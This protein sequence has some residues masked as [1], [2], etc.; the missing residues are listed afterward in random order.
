MNYCEIHLGDLEKAT[1]HLTGVE[2]GM[3]WRLMRWYYDAET[4][5]PLD[6]KAIQRKARAR[7]REE[8]EAVETVLEEFFVQQADGWHQKRCDEEIAKYQAK[9]EKARR[10]AEA[11]WG[12]RPADS[13]R[14]AN[15]FENYA[16]AS[17]EGN[18]PID[19]NA[20]TEQCERNAHQSPVTSHQ[21]PD[22]KQILPHTEIPLAEPTAAGRACLLMRRAGCI[23]TNPSHPALIAALDAGASPEELADTAREAVEAGKN[24]PFAWACITARSR[25]EQLTHGATHA[26][27]PDRGNRRRLSVVERVERN[28]AERERQRQSPDERPVIDAEAVRV[29][30]G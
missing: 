19:A 18:P 12:A 3:Y 27:A 23:Q 22:P 2:D 28:V 16:N 5:L 6:L 14:N 21:S 29:D 17:S 25:R 8:K 10:S 20:S 1:A 30:A 13:E 7:S 15:A 11:R 26:P 24:K 9:K 4:P